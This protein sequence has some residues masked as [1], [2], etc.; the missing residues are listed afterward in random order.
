MVVSLLE[1]GL[2]LVVLYNKLLFQGP[3]REYLYEE[4][5]ML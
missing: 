3:F 5:R 2:R 4:T 1:I